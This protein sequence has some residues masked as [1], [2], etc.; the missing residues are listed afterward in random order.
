MLVLILFLKIMWEERFQTSLLFVGELLLKGC[1]LSWYGS[2][3]VKSKGVQAW[4]AVGEASQS[5][6]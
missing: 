4:S 1:S 6:V 2:E 3:T 5:T